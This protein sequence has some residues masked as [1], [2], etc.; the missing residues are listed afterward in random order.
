[1]PDSFNLSPDANALSGFSTQDGKEA[2]NETARAFE[3][4][5]ERISKALTK[6]ARSGELSFNALAE[7]ITRDLAKMA[8]EDLLLGPL[9][10]AL[11]GGLGQ[12]SGA[13]GAN[14][15]GQRSNI[16]LN[17][18]GVT[19]A[20]SFQRSQSQISAAL[21]RAVNEGQRFT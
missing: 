6:A 11:N 4:A 14:S 7:S 9:Q 10:T 20:K 12:G 13:K 8:I 18:S 19:D 1:M 3:A 15:N 5:G 21:A 2:A 16:T 17:L